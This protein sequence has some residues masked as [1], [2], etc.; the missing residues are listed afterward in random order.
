MATVS[1]SSS[2]ASRLGGGAG[3]RRWAL[4]GLLCACSGTPAP[5]PPPDVSALP[6][7]PERATEAPLPRG[8][9]RDE[10]LLTLAF[11]GEVRGEVEPCGCPTLPYG[12]FAR[13]ERLLDRLRSRERVVHLDAGELLVKG[14]VTTSEQERTERAHVILELSEQVGVAAWAPG[15]TDLMA[16][17]LD[18]LRDVASGRRPGPPP[19]SATWTDVEGRAVLPA[20]RVV[21]VDGV[22]L[23]VV[24]LSAAPADP[25]LQAVVRT[26]DPVDAATA[27][28]ASLPDSVDLVVALGNVADDEADR[29]AREVP[30][31]AAVLTTRGTEVDDPR[32]PTE[33]PTAPGA[34]VVESADR[35]RYLTVVRTRLGTTA[36]T[37]LVLHPASQLWKDLRTL[38]GQLVA[39]SAPPDDATATQDN[40]TPLSGA[41]PSAEDAAA[42]RAERLA[43]A[44]AR[45]EELSAVFGEE[46]RGRNLAYVSAVPL[47]EDLDGDARVSQSIDRFKADSLDRAAERAA[48]PPPPLSTGYAGSGRCASCHTKEVARWAYSAHARAWESLVVRGG[49]DDPE[50]VG[51][52]TTGFG[53]PGGFGELTRGAIGKHKNVQCEVCHGPLLGHPEDPRV[54]AQPVSEVRCL[55]CH[56]AA[57][58]PEF[59]FGPYLAR[60]TCQGGAP[61]LLPDAP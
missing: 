38:Q 50:C 8:P 19:V 7:L 55:R 1:T 3:W 45:L 48:E 20:S 29:V 17:G 60:A 5:A 30:G 43:A 4:F 23:G 54:E 46:G 2:D 31:L 28:V 26:L 12:G 40:G 24:G 57:N 13:R 56:D 41:P 52:H 6:P 27:A 11:V 9:E 39:L 22:Q 16:L 10:A 59:E 32:H 42:A 53:E 51:C 47:A 37:P 49:T 18:G 15:P 44:E 33:D 36:G 35:G 21:D 58:S 25:A 14:L 61:E 34:L